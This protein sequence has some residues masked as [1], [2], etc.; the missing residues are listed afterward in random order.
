MRVRR[1]LVRLGAAS[2]LVLACATPAAAAPYN[3]RAAHSGK[4]LDVAGG[5]GATANGTGL[6]Q[7]DCLGAAQSNQMFTFTPTGDG[8]TYYVAAL[9]SGKCLDVAGGV[10][11][12]A[13]GVTL[14]QFDC[15]G[16]AQAN[17]RWQVVG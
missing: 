7:Y 14:Q 15:L 6:Q 17:Q 12:T 10:A 2:V 13:N 8:S 4:C 11:A 5:P 1:H 9:S 3:I 16:Y